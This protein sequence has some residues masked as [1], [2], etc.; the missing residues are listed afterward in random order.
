MKNFIAA[1]AGEDRNDDDIA[2][3][4]LG[5]GIDKFPEIFDGKVDRHH[6]GHS[7]LL[8]A[9]TWIFLD[10]LPPHSRVEGG[11]ERTQFNIDGDR[12]DLLEAFC[13]E[14]IHM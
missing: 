5:Y 13:F 7:T 12:S 9:L 14:L 1:H 10:E 3:P 4:L 11:L 6:L 8:H 2:E